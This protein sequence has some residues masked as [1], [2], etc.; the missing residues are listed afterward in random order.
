MSNHTNDAIIA[1][2]KG[3]H[4]TLYLKDETKSP[5][6]IS[7]VA[8]PIPQPAQGIPVA[9]LNKQTVLC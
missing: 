7:S 3:I 6:I 2:V 4:N 9:N 1:N 8:L 5:F